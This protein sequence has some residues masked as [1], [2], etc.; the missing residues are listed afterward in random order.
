MGGDPDGDS[1]VLCGIECCRVTSAASGS[2]LGEGPLAVEHAQGGPRVRIGDAWE[3]TF[4]SLSNATRTGARTYRVGAAQGAVLLSVSPGADPDDVEL[5]ETLLHHGIAGGLS[6]PPLSAQDVPM[7]Y[8]VGHPSAPAPASSEAQPTSSPAPDSVP[9]ALPVGG[10]GQ[11]ASRVRSPEDAPVALS[12]IA[13]G[14]AS[15]SS[16]HAARASYT[17]MAPSF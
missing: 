5:F 11:A 2:L 15:L 6:G 13:R 12:L 17:H 10:E 1:D 7:A 8:P 4:A 16:Q 9:Y 3:A 14:Y